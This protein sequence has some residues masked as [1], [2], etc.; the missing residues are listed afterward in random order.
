[1]KGRLN[2]LSDLD[3][4][5]NKVKIFKNPEFENV[6]S[7]QYWE[8]I[9]YPIF[10][11]T[12]K[13]FTFIFGDFNK[14][15]IINE[16]YGHEL[17]TKAMEYSLNLIRDSLPSDSI[18]VR[19]GGDEFCFI[20]PNL[21]KNECEKYI[22]AIHN[23]LELNSTLVSG[24]SIELA[25]ADSTEGTLSD[26]VS[27]TDL[28]VSKIKSSKKE[29]DS[30]AKII[31]SEFI[32]LDIPTDATKEEAEKWVNINNHINVIIYNFL[33]DL[34]P[35]KNFEFTDEQIKNAS[36]FIIDSIGKEAAA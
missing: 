25:S 30:P 35:S 7:K 29:N 11:D 28:E 2:L 17:G 12:N 33:Q 31:S 24:L 15:G 10:N 1:M 9:I 20:V 5:I 27:R 6:Y 16:L 18:I 22:E 19:L 34:R 4:A 3:K 32:P 36:Y 13:K 21:L 14:L 23:S 26:L 8:N